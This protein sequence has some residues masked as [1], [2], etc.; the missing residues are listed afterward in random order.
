LIKNGKRK[1]I[2]KEERNEDK[3]ELHE[4]NGIVKV[5]D[6]TKAEID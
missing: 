1:K 2:R 3:K 6:R 5:K 4:R